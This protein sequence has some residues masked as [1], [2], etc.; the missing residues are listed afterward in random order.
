MFYFI[1]SAEATQIITLLSYVFDCNFS[2]NFQII[3]YRIIVILV[4]KIC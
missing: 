2:F 4:K 3:M 1:F